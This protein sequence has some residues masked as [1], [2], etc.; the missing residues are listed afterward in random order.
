MS[1]SFVK[2]PNFQMTHAALQGLGVLSGETAAPTTAQA[3]SID[4]VLYCP[5]CGKQHIDAPEPGV[6]FAQ[7]AS[8]RPSEQETSTVGEW[9]N[10][11]HRSH[12]CHGCGHI[13]RP[14]DVAT[15]GVAALKTK[16]TAD[17][18]IA[19]QPVAT[20]TEAADA[21][22]TQAARD[23][24]AERRRQIEAEGWTPKH[25]D[26]HDTGEM[27]EAAASYAAYKFNGAVPLSWPWSA[28]WWKPKD[29]RSNLIRAGA[30]I[31][32]EI[33]RLDRA[34]KITQAASKADA[35]CHN[36][37]GGLVGPGV[38]GDLSLCPACDGTGK[39]AQGADAAGGEVNAKEL[40]QFIIEFGDWQLTR[41]RLTELVEPNAGY[42]RN[43]E[44][45]AADSLS[46]IRAALKLPSSEA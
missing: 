11:P 41:G 14:A 30:L 19:A 38:F 34:R 2:R 27:A 39:I 8:G 35:K 23:V 12:L 42:R 45:M 10:P 40:L 7:D 29:R 24:L 36:C 3:A 21:A 44:K 26:E 32:A 15:N 22:L 4:M 17:S 6:I 43:V 37:Y 46:R 20:D 25:D 33:E 16:G 5:A 13:W 31:L 28:Q 9:L 18:P 1:E